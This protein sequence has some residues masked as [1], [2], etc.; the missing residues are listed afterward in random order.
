MGLIIM[1]NH[2]DEK[3]DPKVRK[4]TL[5]DQDHL[6]YLLVHSPNARRAGLQMTDNVEMQRWS[7][8]QWIAKHLLVGIFVHQQLA[9]LITVF[10][11]DDSGQTGEIGYFVDQRW[12]H[13][14]IM[15]TALGQYLQDADYENIVAQ[16]AANNRASQ[17]VLEDNGF[18]RVGRHAGMIHYRWQLA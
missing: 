12:E 5:E 14:H 1:R 6:I 4:L 17:R 10:P 8:R 7:T 18:V 3:Y 15:T 11:D 16:V 9:G 2:Q 13:H